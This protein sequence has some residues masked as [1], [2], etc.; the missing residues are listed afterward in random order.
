MLP[1]KRWHLMGESYWV[2][3]ESSP[4]HILGFFKVTQKTYTNSFL[5]K[6]LWLN[7]SQTW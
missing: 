3:V 4:E 7:F 2:S 5:I 1:Q 6:F